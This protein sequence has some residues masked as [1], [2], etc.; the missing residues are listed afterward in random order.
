MSTRANL[1]GGSGTSIATALFENSPVVP[2]ND[3]WR[4]FAEV[5]EMDAGIHPTTGFMY[6]SS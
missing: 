1:F 4:D 5:V 6:I 3:L 2:E